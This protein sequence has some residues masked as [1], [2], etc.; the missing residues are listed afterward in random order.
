MND[1]SVT[2]DL[3]AVTAY[4]SA[5]EGGYTGTYKEFCDLLGNFTDR[6]D[7][8]K[9]NAEKARENSEAAQSAAAKAGESAEAAAESAK[10]IKL[11]ETLLN[12]KVSAA[13]ASAEKAAKSEE[14]AAKSTQAAAKSEEVAKKSVESIS[15][16]EAAA[17]ESKENAEDAAVRAGESATKAAKSENAAEKSAQNALE[18]TIASQYAMMRTGKKYVTRL[19]KYSAN[20]SSKGT[21]LEDNAGLECVPSTDTTEGRDDYANIPV[22]TWMRCNYIRDEDGFARPIALEGWPEYKTEGAYDVGTLHMTFYWAVED[23]DTY[24]DVILSDTQYDGLKPWAEAVKA[25]GTVMPYWIESAYYSTV[26]SDGLLRS[27]PG[28]APAYNQS[29][30]N[31]I[32]N[33]QKKGAGYWGSSIARNTYAIIMFA[34]KYATKGSQSI[35]AGCNSYNTQVKCAVAETGTKRVL[36]S[37]QEAFIKG[38]CVSVGVANKDST[39]RSNASMHS[40]A[41]RV[42]VKSIETVSVGSASYIALNLDIN[43]TIDTTVDTYVSTMP[44][45]S[46][47]TDVVIGHHDGS[48]VSNSD[49]KHVYRIGGQE[50]MNGQAIIYADTVMEFQTDYS[51]NVYVAPR[52]A[53]HIGNSHEGFDLVGNIPNSGAGADYWSGDMHFDVE[54]GSANPCSIGGGDSVGTGD[55]VWAG[56]T[57]TGLREYYSLGRLW[58][59]SDA[60]ACYVSCWHGLGDANWS[61]GSCD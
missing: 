22:F 51:K 15:G 49:N 52:G 35:M 12:E 54:H 11:D 16:L 8:V 3:G 31:E 13:S 20:T 41:N 14:A 37:K 45:W 58:D 47:T 56:G 19:S 9:A 46:G 34:I 40:I 53:K 36:L 44:Q 39:D 23:H 42:L 2:E 1:Y 29:Y 50:Y 55:R 21:K 38:G 4:A 7:E 57:G 30:N 60:G 25:D 26:A 10:G 59:G 18:Q 5:V 17:R 32:E 27:Q 24:Y 33:Y 28:K 61:Y 48:A 6:A 43:D